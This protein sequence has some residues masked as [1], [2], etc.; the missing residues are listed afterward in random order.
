MEGVLNGNF[1]TSGNLLKHGRFSTFKEKQ[2]IWTL[3]YYCFFGGGGGGM[4][5]FSL[6]LEAPKQSF[7]EI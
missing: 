7:T 4:Q 2:S 1:K 3:Y 5:S 6:I